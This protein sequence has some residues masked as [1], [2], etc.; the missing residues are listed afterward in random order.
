MSIDRSSL[1]KREKRSTSIN[2]NLAPAY[3]RAFYS[4]SEHTAT[5]RRT[6]DELLRPIGRGQWSRGSEL[7]T[8]RVME[9]IEAIAKIDGQIIR[10]KL[11]I[12]SPRN[13]IAV[14]K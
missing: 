4:L 3:L 7:Y 13:T 11:R 5:A 8:S 6:S 14:K 10:W 1:S 12:G 9:T 2:T